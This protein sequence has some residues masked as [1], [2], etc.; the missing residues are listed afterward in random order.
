VIAYDVAH[1]AG[2][3]AI[4]DQLRAVGDR[5]HFAL[6]RAVGHVGHAVDPAA[7]DRHRP[8]PVVDV[9]AE[10]RGIE[11]HRLA[12]PRQPRAIARRSGMGC[13]SDADGQCGT[14]GAEHGSCRPEVRR[15][16]G[17]ALLLVL[18]LPVKAATPA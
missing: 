14:K 15:S 7:A 4:G 17:H 9:R 2:S 18:P 1:D 16:I 11:H 3:D 10:V 13:R 5:D 8:A 12:A 6:G